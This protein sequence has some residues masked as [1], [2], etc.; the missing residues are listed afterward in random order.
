MKHTWVDPFTLPHSTKARFVQFNPTQAGTESVDAV[1]GD[2]EFIAH[3]DDIA[4]GFFAVGHR[5][6]AVLYESNDGIKCHRVAE[7]HYKPR[8]RKDFFR[9]VDHMRVA[10]FGDI[11]FRP[12]VDFF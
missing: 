11:G 8:K 9:A 3:A 1:C 6:R 2:C 10:V 4:D 5:G 12:A 7:T